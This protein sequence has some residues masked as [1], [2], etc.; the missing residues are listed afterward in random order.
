MQTEPKPS[1]HIRK[2]DQVIVIA[3]KEKGKKGRV[4]RLLTSKNRVVVERVNIVKRHT[5]PTQRDPKG[6][7]VEKEGS[8]PVS[9]VLI[10]C[11][12]CDK[13]RRT[14]QQNSGDEK[15]RVCVKCGTAFEAS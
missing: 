4:I 12:T 10:Y 1:F 14:K 11:G 6:G 13:G 8:V 3:G 7:I 15:K 9:N 2:G 5:R